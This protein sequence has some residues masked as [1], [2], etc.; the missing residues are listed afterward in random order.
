MLF[1]GHFQVC[2][3]ITPSSPVLVFPQMGSGAKDKVEVLDDSLFI[4]VE[5]SE[6]T[7]YP[8]LRCSYELHRVDA[9]VDASALPDGSFESLARRMSRDLSK[10]ASGRRRSVAPQQE[11]SS[12]FDWVECDLNNEEDEANEN[13]DTEATHFYSRQ[14]SSTGGC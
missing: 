4:Y 5:N 9:A 1:A 2:K 7:S 14:R 10:L 6:S 12:T 8:G 13:D 3:P 11:K